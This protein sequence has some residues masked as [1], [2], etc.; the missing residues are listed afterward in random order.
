MPRA[1]Y[2][3]ISIICPWMN[4]SESIEYL[5]KNAIDTSSDDEPDSDSD[6]LIA[7]VTLM[8]E[9]TEAQR[10]RHRVSTMSR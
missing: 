2:I 5:Y 1:T 6:L 9:H 7:T 8:N 4:F 10:P 3:T